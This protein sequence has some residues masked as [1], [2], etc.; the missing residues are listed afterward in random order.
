[1]IQKEINSIK[2]G[3]KQHGDQLNKFIHWYPTK[4]KRFTRRCFK[5]K[6]MGKDINEIW[7]SK[8]RI[9]KHF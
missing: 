4:L 8:Q 3:I 2:N 6:Q 5:H 1:M 7:Y 9:N